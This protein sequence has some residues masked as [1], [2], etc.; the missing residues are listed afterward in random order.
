MAHGQVID[1]VMQGVKVSEYA[2][3]HE[4][5]KTALTKWGTGKTGFQM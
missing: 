1:A 2:E 3:E 4:E 5:L